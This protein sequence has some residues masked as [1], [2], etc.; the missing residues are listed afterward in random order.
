MITYLLTIVVLMVLTFFW[1]VK[2]VKWDLQVTGGGGQWQHKHTEM[3]LVLSLL[4]PLGLV[5]GITI[6]LG[7]AVILINRK[8]KP[9]K[10]LT[11]W[12]Q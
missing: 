6:P 11:E 3:C 9:L 4:F 12:L 5:V 10:R 1:L 7:L 2:V 8:Y